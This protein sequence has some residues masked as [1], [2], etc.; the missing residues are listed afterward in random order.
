MF[1]RKV[2]EGIRS[3]TYNKI[4]CVW[5]DVV[6]MFR[7]D[8]CSNMLFTIVNANFLNLEHEFRV[9]YIFSIQKKSCQRKKFNRKDSFKKSTYFNQKF[10]TFS[11]KKIIQYCIKQSMHTKLALIHRLK[12]DP[13]TKWTFKKT[14][15]NTRNL[16]DKLEPLKT[17]MLFFLNVQIDSF[18]L[19]S[20]E[21]R[22]VQKRA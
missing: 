15:T 19:E 13:N 6:R 4:L 3:R 21:R 20:Y 16:N 22:L 2:C 10:N 14:H 12:S 17:S 18:V 11:N 1:A 7:F 8:V 5:P 9:S